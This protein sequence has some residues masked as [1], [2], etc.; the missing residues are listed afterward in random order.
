MAFKMTHPDSTSE[1]KVDADRVEMYR[2]QGWET[3]PTA[4]DPEPADDKPAK[5]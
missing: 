2:S 3:A 4:K 1:I 5:K